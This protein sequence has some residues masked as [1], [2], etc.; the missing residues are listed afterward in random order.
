MT[1]VLLPP[2][3][4][5]V[6][7]LDVEPLDVGP[8]FIRT[9][10]MSRWHRPRTGVQFSEGHVTYTVWC[11]QIIG[12]RR[13]G[14]F[15]TAEQPREGELVCATCEG[16]AIGAGQEQAAPGSPL[17]VFSPRGLTPPRHCP[18]SRTSLYRL[19]SGGAAGECLACGDTHPLRAMGGPYASRTAIVQHDPGAA[20]V[21]PCPFHRW[22]QPRHAEGT[23]QCA[24]GRPMPAPR[25]A[26]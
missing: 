20:L 23:V 16:R 15:L 11:G 12:G 14:G 22:R 9:R 26:R 13:R 10:A 17:L 7:A 18:G 5:S 24:C 2:V 6:V 3:T 21:A 4:G 1:V 19:L 8:R 25:E